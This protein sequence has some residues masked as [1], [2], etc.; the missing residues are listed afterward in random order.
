MSLAANFL[1]DSYALTA[2]H[3]ISSYLGKSVSSKTNLEAKDAM[4][5]ASLLAAIAASNA[6]IGAVHAMAH[7]VGGKFDLP[8]G[9]ANAILLPYVMEYNLPACVEKFAKI[10]E[11]LGQPMQNKSPRDAAKGAIEAVRSLAREVG[12]VENFST[13]GCQLSEGFIDQ[14]SSNAAKDACLITNPRDAGVE[15]ICQIFRHAN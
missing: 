3:L 15:D 12:I 7:Q 10:A 13:A 2:I 11:A 14:L 6:L 1:T 9:M 4:A 8:H 5:K